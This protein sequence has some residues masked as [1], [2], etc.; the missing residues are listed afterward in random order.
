MPP[1]N[2]GPEELALGAVVFGACFFLG[3]AILM[4]LMGQQRQTSMVV[5]FQQPVISTPAASPVMSNKEVIEWQDWRGRNR[6]ITIHR[7]VH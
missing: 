5:P 3:A 1:A 6:T 4:V 7:E 2:P